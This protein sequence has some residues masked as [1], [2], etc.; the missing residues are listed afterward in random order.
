[1]NK[2]L[3]DYGQSSKF[4][5]EVI[6]Y[7]SRLDTL[8]A[9]VLNTKMPHLNA[10]NEARRKV[11]GWYRTE[12]Q[13]MTLKLPTEAPDAKSVYHLFVIQVDDRDLCLDYL[14]EKEIMVQI[15]YPSLIHLQP[16]YAHLGYGVGDFPIAE[17][18]T[19]KTLSWFN[20]YSFG[21]WVE[22]DRV[23]DDFNAVRIGKGVKVSAV[24]DEPYAEERKGNGFIFSQIF[25]STSGVNRLNQ[26]ILALPITKDINPAYGSIQKLHAR[27]TDLITLCEDKVLKVLANKDALFNA[28]GNSNITSNKAVLGQTI[29][30]I[31]EYG[32][33]KNP[34][35]YASYGF[36]S[37]FTDKNRG[38]VLR[39]SRNGL[40]EISSKGMSDYFSD[41]L[42]TENT[43]ISSRA[44]I[45]G[46]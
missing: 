5:H 13:N 32:I 29:P 2:I 43:I 30:Y 33:S 4:N 12:L 23:R 38:V 42:S 7:N 36:R 16:C 26:F 3:S 21:N 9:A 34:E 25:N 17:A 44:M 6:G 20:C 1:M 11:A 41:K 14:H 27:D 22:S 8:Q 40:D 28:D 15:H 31:G 35:S 37:F 24:L 18:A 19:I 10:W 45:F 39:L 46:F